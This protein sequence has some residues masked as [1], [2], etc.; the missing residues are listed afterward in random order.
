[1]IDGSLKDAT[2]VSVGG[3]LDQVGSDGIVD[4][5]V[6]LGYELVQALLD[7]LEVVSVVN[8]EAQWLAKYHLHGYRSSP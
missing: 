4:E 6:V 3:D 2:S 8:F 5:L 1:M 7:H